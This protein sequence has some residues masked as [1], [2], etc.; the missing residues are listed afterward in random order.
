M[1]VKHK[2]LNSYPLVG[3]KTLI[4]GTFNPDVPCNKAEFFY[5][6]AK[7]YFWDLLP[8]VF[9]IESL[10]GDV[11][12]QKEFLETYDIEL[13]DLILSVALNEA[14]I[15]NY[16]DDKL[17]DIKEWNTTTILDIL[18]KSKTK[19]VYFTRKSFDKSVEN[20]KNE[21]YKIK[22]YCEKNKIKFAFLPTPSRFKDAKKLQEWQESFNQTDN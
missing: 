5:G 15:C 21:I 7:N 20:I 13:S 4:I 2:F 11:Q 22:D 8:F 16:G 6:R 10:K 14:D 19:E 9:G 12:K 17:K 1:L 18:K 3:K